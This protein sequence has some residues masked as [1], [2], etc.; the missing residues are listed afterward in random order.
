MNAPKKILLIQTAF[1]G[2][3]ILATALI[4]KLHTHFSLAKIDFLVRKGNESVLVQHPLINHLF[5][6]DK[7]KKWTSALQLLSTIR[8]NKY[9]KVI[10]VQ[11]HFTTGIIT[12]FSGAKE[13]IGFKKNPLSFLFHR[14]VEHTFDGIHEIERNQQLIAD[15][16]DTVPA[17]P[18]LYIS[19]SIQSQVSPYQK[20]KMITISAGSVWATKKYP[21][22]KW[23]DFLRHLDTSYTVYFLGSKAEHEEI[24]LM[25]QDLK[26]PNVFNLCGQLNLVAS[27]ALMEKADMNYANDSAPTH[28]ASAIN[29]PMASIF[30]STSPRYGYGP[31]SDLSCVIETQQHL[32]CKP[33]TNHGKK[34]CPLNHFH[35]G[36]TIHTSQ[37]IDALKSTT[38]T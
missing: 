13:T 9:D 1:L 6:L 27:A 3:V 34:K 10:N 22:E 7:Q 31:L 28:L 16:T 15:C 12:A 21:L 11:R 38:S 26:M 8:K 4:E 2:D 23:I 5:V 33:C 24:K 20:E 19:P 14:A 32:A 37:L 18:K 35:C 30:C 17:Q 29:A 25:L 36:T